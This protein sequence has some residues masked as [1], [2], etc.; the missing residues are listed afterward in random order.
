[1]GACGGGDGPAVTTTTTSSSSSVKRAPTFGPC[2]P[3]PAPGAAVDWLPADLPLPPGTYPVREL[4]PE[5]N[6]RRALFVVPG[7]PDDFARFTVEHW[8]AQGWRLLRGESETVE[9]ENRFVR[10]PAFGG[11]KARQRYCDTS[12]S[13]LTLGYAP[14]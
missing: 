3:A 9:T 7:T 2:Q 4:A 14:G 10:S 6:V 1:L 5:G 13:E 12:K 8:P 11:Y